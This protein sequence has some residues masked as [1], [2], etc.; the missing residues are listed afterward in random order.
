MKISLSMKKKCLL[1]TLLANFLVVPY[2]KITK[3]FTKKF[4]SKVIN[5]QYFHRKTGLYTPCKLDPFLT[6]FLISQ[7]IIYLC[8]WASICVCAFV[9]L[10]ILVYWSDILVNSDLKTLYFKFPIRR[11]F[12]PVVKIVGSRIVVQNLFKLTLQFQSCIE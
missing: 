7:P 11:T 6:Y 5:R 10:K 12:A 2:I 3:K 4:G 9:S 1:I 8:C